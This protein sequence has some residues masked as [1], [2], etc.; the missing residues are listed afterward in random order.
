MQPKAEMLRR[1]QGLWL[2]GLSLSLSVCVGWKKDENNTHES[3]SKDTG[4]SRVERS[5]SS[6]K[7]MY[8][9][10]GAYT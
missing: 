3:G 2:G 9:S 1:R 5:I 10:L 7:F 6:I 8:M 4:S